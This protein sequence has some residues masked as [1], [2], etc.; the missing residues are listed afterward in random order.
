MKMCNVL[1]ILLLIIVL[2]LSFSFKTEIVKKIFP[3][4]QVFLSRVVSV[5][6]KKII[7]LLNKALADEWLSYYQYWIGSKV[8][9]G[10]LAKDII[11]ELVEHSNDE[12]RHAEMLIPHILEL[13][14]IPILEFKDIKKLSTCGY[15]A[16]GADGQL[17]LILEQNISGERCAIGVYNQL[18][19]L[20]G[21]EYEK[22][23][24]DLN[25]ILKEEKEHE[26]DLLKLLEKFNF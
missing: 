26:D 17:K 6:D 16:P 3:R 21:N 18:I 5:K 8:A 10:N 13:G 24:L 22:L 1:S 2:V 12:K 15:A 19:K 25:M 14:G 4:K 9:K 7:E 11:I 23:S 20:T